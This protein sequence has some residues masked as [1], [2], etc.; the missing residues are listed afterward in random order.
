MQLYLCFG[1]CISKMAREQAVMMT[2]SDDHNFI[3]YGLLASHK[4]TA[5]LTQV[6]IFAAWSHSGNKALQV[7]QYSCARSIDD[8]PTLLCMHTHM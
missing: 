7:K 6:L 4:I 3:V 1:D 8:V 5:S 2:M